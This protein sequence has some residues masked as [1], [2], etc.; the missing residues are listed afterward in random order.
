MSWS[1]NKNNSVLSI[2]I[3]TQCKIDRPHS[4]YNIIQITGLE[5]PH[6]NVMRGSINHISVRHVHPATTPL[7]TFVYGRALFSNLSFE[8]F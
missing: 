5:E 1:S 6:E 8:A 7:V 2:L 4:H 3:S